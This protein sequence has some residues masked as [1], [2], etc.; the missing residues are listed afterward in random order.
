MPRI[1]ESVV[2]I[3]LL[4]GLGVTTALISMKLVNMEKSIPDAI[5][6]AFWIYRSQIVVLVITIFLLLATAY[7]FQK[8]INP[9]EKIS[10][11]TKKVPAEVYERNKQIET[12]QAV[13]KLVESEAYKKYLDDK[14]N[15]RLRDIQFDEDD[16]IVL[17]DDSSL[18][19]ED[20]KTRRQ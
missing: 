17:S 4:G 20:E 7:F 12:E 8:S 6:E 11:W 10:N 16:Q 18:V 3:S 5:A 1:P 14:N 2:L 9:V 19:E 13:R 15:N